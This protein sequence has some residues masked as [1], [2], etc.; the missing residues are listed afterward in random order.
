MSALRGAPRHA[1]AAGAVAVAVLAVSGC[2]PAD[3]DGRSRL[4]GSAVSAV[5]DRLAS[6][7]L[8]RAGLKVDWMTCTARLVYGTP[9]ATAS[10]ASRRAT[11]ERHAN[12]ARVDCRGQAAGREI[13]VKGRVVDERHGRCVI[14]DLEATVG[15]RTVFRAKGLGDC[16]A[17]SSRSGV[18]GP[19]KPSR[20]SGYT[21][22]YT[23]SF[24]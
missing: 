12:A 7:A 18:S 22:S 4:R 10:G 3:G 23:P 5:T 20:T 14:G 1:V 19:P 17:P 9:P 2:E 13:T 8:E 6:E 21:P 16:N 24:R 15:G 11:P